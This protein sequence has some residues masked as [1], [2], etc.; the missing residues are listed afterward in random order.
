MVNGSRFY[1]ALE[2][3]SIASAL[4]LLPFTGASSES[5]NAHIGRSGGRPQRKVYPRRLPVNC[6]THYVSRHRTHNLPIVSPTRYQLCYRDHQIYCNFILTGINI[7]QRNI[8]SYS[9]SVR[10]SVRPSSVRMSLWNTPVCAQMVKYIVL[11]Q[12]SFWSRSKLS[13]HV[14]ISLKQYYLSPRP[15][16]TWPTD[17]FRRCS[18]H[19]WLHEWG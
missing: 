14:L 6:D 5:I 2:S 17:Y 16:S 1:R 10:P 11:Q 9:S 4:P 3:V 13:V 8:N 7:V 18:R 12:R 19:I 15:W